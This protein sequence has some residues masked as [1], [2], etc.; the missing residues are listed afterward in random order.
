MRNIIKITKWL[1]VAAAFVATACQEDIVSWDDNLNDETTPAGAPK[2]EYIALASDTT[3]LKTHITTGNL[4]DMLAIYGENLSQLQSLY[5]NDVAVEL[6]TVYAVNSRIIVPIPRSLPEEIT[7]KITVTTSKGTT[8]YDFTV[9]I[10]PLV[11]T[12]LFNEFCSAGDTVDIV[13]N[14]FDLYDLT[15]ENAQVSI[16]GA[17]LTIL[18]G[19]VTTLKVVI[20]AG[21]ADNTSITVSSPKMDNPATVKFRDFGVTLQNYG[22][23]VWG[24]TQKYQTDGTHAGDPKPLKGIPIFQRVNATLAQWSWNVPYAWG[25]N[26]PESYSDAPQNYQLKFEILTLKNISTGDFILGATPDGDAYRYKWNPAAGGIS[27][28]TF[29]K[30]KTIT[31]EYSELA[32]V[33][34]APQAGQWGNFMIAYQPTKEG[35][36]IAD[37]SIANARIVHK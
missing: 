15:V 14:N 18:D 11:I 32:A 17:K 31:I 10:P 33:G 20:P 25:L 2:I 29:G 34:W 26:W 3:S 21:T 24:D 36:T 8:E 5:F 37:F 6:K 9:S 4:S 28:D 7:N 1:F 13:G 16:N 22:D 19:T 27:F 30:W 23:G 12:S 35:E